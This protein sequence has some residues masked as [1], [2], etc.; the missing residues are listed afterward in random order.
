MV[1]GSKKGGKKWLKRQVMAK[2][3]KKRQNW[4]KVAKKSPNE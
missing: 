2:W 4:L 1:R 3:G